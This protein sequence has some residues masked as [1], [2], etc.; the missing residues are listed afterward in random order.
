M[1]FFSLCRKTCLETFFDKSDSYKTTQNLQICIK[2]AKWNVQRNISMH[3]Q[4]K[5]SILKVYSRK[6]LKE[7]SETFFQVLWNNEYGHLRLNKEWINNEKK[8]HELTV[9]TGAINL[10]NN[11]NTTTEHYSFALNQ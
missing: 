3:P 1:R 5:I 2:Q 10:W 11:R 9:K 6:D 4:S 8:K 7:E